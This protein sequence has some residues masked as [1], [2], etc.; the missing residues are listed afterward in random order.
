MAKP[1]NSSIVELHWAYCNCPTRRQSARNWTQRLA[2]TQQ[3]FRSCH[4]SGSTNNLMG[5]YTIGLRLCVALIGWQF[6]RKWWSNSGIWFNDWPDRLIVCLANIIVS[7]CN[8]RTLMA[9]YQLNARVR[10]VV[11]PKR[12]ANKQNSTSSSS[13]SSSSSL[14]LF[15]WYMRI[16]WRLET[17]KY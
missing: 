13:S 7:I 16:L 1:N 5:S 2:I 6:L 15:L 8:P 3:A 11:E 17:R 14:F 12:K 4:Q 9:S 10:D